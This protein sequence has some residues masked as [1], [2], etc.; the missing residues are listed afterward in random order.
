MGKYRIS[1]GSL[2]SFWLVQSNSRDREELLDLAIQ[3]AVNA[4]EFWR[5]ASSIHPMQRESAIPR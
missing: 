5:S 4:D 3:P 1:C 2:G